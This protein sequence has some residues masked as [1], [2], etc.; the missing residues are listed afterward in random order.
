VPPALDYTQY[1]LSI[2][3]A[4]L[5]DAD[6]LGL[7]GELNSELARQYPEP[8]ANH[9]RLDPDEVAPG[10]GVILIARWDGQPVGCGAVRLIDAGTAELKRMFA[11]PTVRGRGVGRALL[12]ALEAEARTLG[13]RQLVLE[14]GIRQSEAM[15]LYTSHGFVHMP[16]FG[17]YI[18]SPLS[19]CM[20]KPLVA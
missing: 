18:D 3:R 20:Q 13:A 7:I 5:G 12:A 9:F 14:T 19:V 17:E 4:D 16:P 15:G 2:S 6:L 10:R 1:V 11:R 8:G